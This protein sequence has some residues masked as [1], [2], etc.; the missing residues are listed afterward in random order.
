[1]LGSFGI[2]T[3]GLMAPL[4][5]MAVGLL[6]DTKP[7]QAV[8][9]RELTNKIGLTNPLGSSIA[10]PGEADPASKTGTV[11]ALTGFLSLNDAFGTSPADGGD[12]QSSGPGAAG[13]GDAGP[14]GS[15]GDAAAAGGSAATGPGYSNG[16]K[17]TGPGSGIS[18]SIDAKL[19]HGEFVTSADVVAVPGVRQLLEAL[20][21]QFH[22]PAA[23]QK[24]QK[25][26]MPGR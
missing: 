24:M 10:G 22:T 1:M 17:V 11:D 14:G 19:S 8:F 16:G 9:A 25:A 26:H 6:T 7:A 4:A 2:S 20:Q 3:L 15:S 13:M 12:G 23:M 21:E 5:A 18:D